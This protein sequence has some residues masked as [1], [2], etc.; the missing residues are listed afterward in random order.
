MKYFDT[1]TGEEQPTYTTNVDTVKCAHGYLR[2][3]D[4]HGNY[5][6]YIHD[7]EF[8]RVIPSL[9]SYKSMINALSSGEN[10]IKVT[11]RKWEL[12]RDFLLDEK[13]AHINLSHGVYSSRTCALCQVYM[14]YNDDC[15]DG[16]E[17]D[18]CPLFE[19]GNG[20]MT[21]YEIYDIMSVW[22]TFNEYRTAENANKMVNI[23]KELM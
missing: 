22:E 9:T 14:N 17:C 6:G 19:A 16:K 13:N 10:P 18:S 11:L 12:I 3:F 15:A 4:V 21:Q 2:A 7:G 5:M 8:S 23:I 20:C 1:Q